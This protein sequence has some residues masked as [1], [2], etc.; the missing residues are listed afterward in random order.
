MKITQHY[1][2]SKKNFYCYLFWRKN[3]QMVL[4]E[5]TDI[6]NKNKQIQFIIPNIIHSLD[7]YHLMNVILH[8]N[9]IKPVI[10]VYDYFG[11]DP[12]NLSKLSHIVKNRI[13]KNIYKF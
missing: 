4:R 2:K 11:T 13:H 10:T 1:L 9:N 6:L 12:N 8:S 7:T 3:Y 5:K